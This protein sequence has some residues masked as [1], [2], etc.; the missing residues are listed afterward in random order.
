[1]RVKYIIHCTLFLMLFGMHTQHI[2]AMNLTQLFTQ[3]A[4]ITQSC[5]QAI[6]NHHKIAISIIAGTCTSYFL[7]RVKHCFINK[8]AYYG[9]SWQYTF[10]HL[11]GGSLNKDSEEARIAFFRNVASNKVSL[12]RKMLNDGINVQDTQILN[13]EQS[14]LHEATRLG[15]KS[16]AELLIRYGAD[17]HA[18]NVLG[19][20]PLH[21]AAEFSPWP[22][23]QKNRTAIARMLLTHGACSLYKDNQE[24]TPLEIA[25]T[26]GNDS[27]VQLL[28][29]GQ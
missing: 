13:G 11:L 25:Q 12:V 15:Y 17:L 23:I 3:C 16:M 28:G 7:H 10:W 19:Q 4:A 26:Y 1:M 9:R 29:S 8:C 24:H 21:I 20:T 14:A 22:H 18:T 2:N 27:M 6:K 5:I